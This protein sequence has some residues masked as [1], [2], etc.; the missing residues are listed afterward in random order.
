V[1]A[2][3]HRLRNRGDGEGQYATDDE[4]FAAEFIA[5][6]RVRG[7]RPVLALLPEQRPQSSRGSLDPEVKAELFGRF[8]EASQAIRSGSRATG[9]QPALTEDNDTREAS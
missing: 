9:G 7:W 1:A 8:A 4:F 5:A 2:L 6:L 3:V